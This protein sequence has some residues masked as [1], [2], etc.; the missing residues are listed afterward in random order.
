[1]SGDVK[2]VHKGAVPGP[3]VPETRPAMHALLR[4]SP[5]AL[6]L[7]AAVPSASAQTAPKGKNAPP[8]SVIAEPLQLLPGSPL[9]SRSLTAKPGPVASKDAR[10]WT[11]ETRLHRGPLYAVALAASPDGRHFIT[12]GLDGVA[13]VWEV[14]T[15]RFVRA[16]V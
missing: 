11:L 6:V 8:T 13:R 10:S 2:V 5:F 9:S 12:G 4:T 3:A 7:L 16:L 14:A 15:G 1:M